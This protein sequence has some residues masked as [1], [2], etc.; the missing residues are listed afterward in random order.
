MPGQIDRARIFPEAE[1]PD[2]QALIAEGRKTAKTIK[3]GTSPFLE[4]FGV[5]SEADY[6]RRAVAEG[7]VMMHAQ[8][9]FRAPDKS[10]RAYAEIWEALD[11]AGHRVDRYGI[12]LDWSMGY[13]RAR[14]K[15]MP[16]GT[17]LIMVETEDW[18]AM[19]RMAPVAPHFGDFVIGTPAAF[20]NT[21]AALLA[22]S[23]SI[24][25]LG[26]YFSFRQ[27]HWDDDVFTTAESLKAI[28]LTAAQPV[29]VIVHSSLDDGFA[30]LF[31]DLACSLGAI[32]LEQYIV[33]DLCGGH[34]SYSFGN[35]YARPYA[36]HAFQRAAQQITRTPGTMI[37]GATTMYGENHAANYAALVTYLRIDI[38]GQKTRPAGHAVNPTPVT[39]AERI[40]DI[41]EIIDA[42]RLANHLVELEEPLGGLYRDEEIDPIADRIVAGGRRFKENVLAGFQEAGIDIENPFEMLLAIR[43]VGSKRLEELFGPGAPTPGRLRGRAPVSPSHSIEQLEEMGQGLVTRMDGAARSRIETAGLRACIATTD[44]HEYGKILIETVLGKL[45]VTIV[46]GGTSTD[47]NDLALQLQS[48]GA[49]FVALSSYNGVAL[50]FVSELQRDLGRLGIA[51]PIF[52]GGKLNRVPDGS[53]TSLPV[54]IRDE[55]A[56]AGAIVCPGVETMLERISDMVVEQA[57]APSA[58]ESR[59]AP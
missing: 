12:C 9:G 1:L 27:P 34:A 8:I 3:V 40:P 49:H 55:L 43:R 5:G 33:D 17:G 32:L 23:T 59:S 57:S 28:A 50:D 35:T 10:R 19:T 2:A 47:P 54:D 45:G 6:K 29:E 15:N 22:G 26:Q 31:T 16:R 36:R 4:T 20:E 14:R 30:S 18:I 51:V 52:V 21:I 24:G 7:R 58:L 42:H 53:N 46:D 11:K 25:N 48:T 13:P 39:E 56:A 44:V 37:Y 41:D 38:H